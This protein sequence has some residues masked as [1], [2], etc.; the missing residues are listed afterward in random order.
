MANRAIPDNVIR[1]L[2]EAVGEENITTDPGVLQV[3]SYMNSLMSAATGQWCKSP[4]GV[5]L[6]GSR[7]DVIALIKICRENGIKVKPQTTAWLY[8]SLACSDN[9][10]ILDLR[11]MNGLLEINKDDGYVVLEPYCTSGEQQVEMMKKGLNSHVNGAGPNACILP[12]ATSVQGSGGTSMSMS[13]SERNTLAVELVTTSGEIVH[14]GSPGTP[15]AGWFCGDGPGP[16]LRG[17]MR[18]AVGNLGGQGVYTR[19]GTKCYPWYGPPFDCDGEP[20]FFEAE[21]LPHFEIRTAFWPDYDS[22]CDALYRIGEAELTDYCARLAAGAYE[23]V[24]ST[25]N[26]EYCSIEK[27]GIFRNTFPKGA[28]T[29]TVAASCPE[30]LEARLKVLEYIIED[31]GGICIDVSDLGTDAYQAVFQT[32][33][34]GCYI[35]KAAFMPSGAM[36]CFTPMSYETIDNLWK[37]NIDAND[38]IKKDLLAEEMIAD[39]GYDN[40]YCSLDENGHYGHIESPY[41]VDFW[42]PKEQSL[43][44]MAVGVME[45]VRK[46]IPIL[47]SP[48]TVKSDELLTYAS[49]LGKIQRLIDSNG[50]MDS[51]MGGIMSTIRGLDEIEELRTIGERKRS[52]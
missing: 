15:N 51:W 37:V 33:V 34:R 10:L 19:I 36:G 31:T 3:Y 12:S 42:E 11:R 32:T 18:G 41:Q 24:V 29:L 5:A 7:E 9:V 47:Y 14:F 6:P 45:G 38:P 52:A 8:T 2:Q 4:V 21:R 20:P 30:E 13:N 50:T 39:D 28:W 26:E 43:T 1:Q 49:Y 46:H 44:G 25:T 23:G 40:N 48:M 35:F 16:S 17:M 22:E 27:S